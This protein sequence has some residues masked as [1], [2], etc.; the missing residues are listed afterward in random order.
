MN[1]T[2]SYP[3]KQPSYDEMFESFLKPREHYREIFDQLSTFE[4]LEFKEKENLSKLVSINQGITFTVYNDGK[5]I[6]RIFPFDLIPRI[7]I[8]SEWDKIE[9][10]VQQRLKALNMFLNDIYHE[11]QIIKDKII[12]E[13]IIL[14]CPDYNKQMIGVNVPH[15]IYTHIAGIDIIR[16]AEGEYCVLEDNLRTPS[17][18]SYVLENRVIMKRIFPEIFKESS[19]LR[20]D[21]YPAMLY[22][23]LKSLAPEHQSNPVVVL[24]TPGVYNSAYY[25]H[26]FL[27]SQMGIQLVENYDLIVQDYKVYMRTIEG[28]KQVDVIYKRIDDNF[29]DP[30]VFKK[31]SML[32]VPGLF[33]CYKKGNVVLVNAIGNGIADDKSIYIYVPDMI[34]YY[35]NESPILKSIPTYKMSDVNQRKEAFGKM[36]QLVIKATNQSGGYGMLIGNTATEEEIEEYKKKIIENPRNYIA[37]PIISLSTAPCFIND[38]IEPRHIDFR[39]FAIYSPD[40]I[41]LIPGGLTRVALKK[42]S[43]V[44]NSSQGGGSKDTWV[45]I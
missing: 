30:I 9:A 29:L 10:G 37:Q 41:K 4:A 2:F 35:L 24:L 1:I 18:I 14:T 22:D 28:L 31:D 13:D 32:G 5:G 42:G 43:L 8:K 44:V 34:K 6:E 16:D 40:G 23:M 17:G 20:I 36:D 25:E 11:Q 21:N 39:P 27:A 19:V 33:E 7:V 38:K 15:G 3:E 12:P 26:V 45:V